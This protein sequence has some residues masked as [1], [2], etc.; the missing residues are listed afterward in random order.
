VPSDVLFVVL[1][2][3]GNRLTLLLLG[4]LSSLFATVI[5]KMIL[6]SK[7]LHYSNLVSFSSENSYNLWQTVNKV[8]RHHYLPAPHPLHLLTAL[9]Y[10]LLIKYPSFIFL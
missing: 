8:L 1:R 2:R 4:H 6:D 5:I 9:H 7:E 10:F 3:F